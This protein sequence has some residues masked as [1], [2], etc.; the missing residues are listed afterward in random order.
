MAAKNSGLP[1]KPNK[2]SIK[3]LFWCIM[4]LIKKTNSEKILIEKIMPFHQLSNWCHNALVLMILDKITKN[5]KKCIILNVPIIRSAVDQ[6]LWLGS[7]LNCPEIK[8]TIMK[9]K[10]DNKMRFFDGK[11]FLSFNIKIM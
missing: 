3:I 2:R 4:W 11:Y 8:Q 5:M 9:N 10:K 1:V 7:K 6:K